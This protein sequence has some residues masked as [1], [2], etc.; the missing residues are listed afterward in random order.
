MS[1]MCCQWTLATCLLYVGGP[2]DFDRGDW[3]GGGYFSNVLALRRERSTRP[4]SSY[5]TSNFPN[6]KTNGVFCSVCLH[7]SYTFPDFKYCLVSTN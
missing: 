2:A 5:E 6:S 7:I 3:G 1:S 4:V